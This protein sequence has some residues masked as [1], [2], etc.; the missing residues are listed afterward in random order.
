MSNV[1]PTETRPA[2]DAL[3]ARAI[4]LR[5]EM[6]RASDPFAVIT[7]EVLDD[8]HRLASEAH[9]E[10][11]FKLAEF[12]GASNQVEALAAE[13]DSDV[14]EKN[15]ER[16]PEEAFERALENEALAQAE[17]LKA[18]ANLSLA[19]A[20]MDLAQSHAGLARQDREL[21]EIQLRVSNGEVSKEELEEI[22]NQVLTGLEQNIGRLEV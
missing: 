10:A 8:L 5:D 6:S 18:A 13:T 16:S 4:N 11:T 14:T 1:A 17:V 3:Q 9:D 22:M 12:Q 15:V 21:A 20:Q 19:Q 2:F 7:D